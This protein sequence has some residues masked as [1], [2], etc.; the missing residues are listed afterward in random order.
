MRRPIAFLIAGIVIATAIPVLAQN[1]MYR[2]FADVQSTD[3][4]A[5]DVTR[6]VDEGI[7]KGYDDGRF[8][9]NDPLTRGQMATI[10]RRYDSNMIQPLREQIRVLRAELGLGFCGDGK[11]QDGEQCDDGNVR[12]GD[13]CSAY[14]SDQ[15]DNGGGWSLCSGGH[16][17]GDSYRSPDGCNTC[18]CTRNGEICTLRY[19]SPDPVPD[20]EPYHCADGTEIDRCTA[21]GHVIN[22]FAPPCMTHGGEVSQGTRCMGDNDCPSGTVCSTRY[23]DCESACDPGVEACIQ[24]C[25]GRCTQSREEETSCNELRQ[26]FDD[27]AANSTYCTNTSD[28]TIVEASCPYVTCG[29]AV[30]VSAA[31]SVKNAADEYASCLERSGESVSCA[32]CMAMTAR[33]VNNRCVTERMR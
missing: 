24:A 29:V 2:Q 14:C 22:Y 13:G 20:C 32:G 30:S 25:A 15:E 19:C 6:L 9:P 17:I 27:M 31:R 21:D 1:V 8:G 23:G 5:T 28:C 4:Y 18:S 3:F 12:S 33:C 11:L 7:L 10:L 16:Q 26:D